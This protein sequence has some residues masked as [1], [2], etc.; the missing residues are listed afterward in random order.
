MVSETVSY[1]N[2]EEENLDNL[3]LGCSLCLGCMVLVRLDPWNFV[4]LSLLFEAIVDLVNGVYVFRPLKT[5]IN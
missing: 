2:E 5:Q 3:L 1:K 4:H